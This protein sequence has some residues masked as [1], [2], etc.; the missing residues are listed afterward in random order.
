MNNLEIYTYT[1]EDL[2]NSIQTIEYPKGAT[3]KKCFINNISAPLLICNNNTG[4]LVS[5]TDNVTIQNSFTFTTSVGTIITPHGTIIVN[6]YY[7]NSDGQGLLPV[8]KTIKAKPTFTS[9]IYENHKDIVV[10]ITALD[11]VKFT[12]ILTISY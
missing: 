2:L 6:L 3:E 8:N 12:R 9:G 11:D 4:G 5:Y 10:T 7:D 1:K